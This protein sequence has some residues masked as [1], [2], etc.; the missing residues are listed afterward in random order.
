MIELQPPDNFR[1]GTPDN[2][3]TE[4]EALNALMALILLG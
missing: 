2:L 3:E 4:S 1:L